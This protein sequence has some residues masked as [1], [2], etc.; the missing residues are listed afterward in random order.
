[1]HIVRRAKLLAKPEVRAAVEKIAEVIREALPGGSFAENELAAHAMTGEA[2]RAVLEEKLQR[3]ADSFGDRVLVGDVEFKRHEPGTVNVYSLCGT[4]RPRRFTFRQ[5][6]V[7]NGPTVDPMALVAG[8]V[9]GATPALAYSV[10]HGYAQ[11]DMRAHGEA[12]EAAERVAPPRATLERL[13]K[14]IAQQADEVL[15]R[16]EPMLRRAEAVPAAAR[17]VS[18]GL[19]R[20]SVL[21]S[22]ERPADAPPK[23][24]RK[25]KKPRIRRPSPPVDVNWRMAY[26]GTVSIVDADG[27]ALTSRRYAVPACDDPS[28][29][30]ARMCADVE[31]A[32][33]CAPYLEV[34][35]V[36]DGAPEMWNVTRGG[37]EQLLECGV[38]PGWHEG[39][40]R[41][42]LLERLAAAL[43]IIEPDAEE[44]R[45]VLDEWR[46]RLDAQDSAIDSIEHYLTR[47]YNEASPKQQEQLWEH[48]RYLQNNK[49]RMRYVT[50]QTAGLPVGS[51]VTESAAKTVVGRRAKN[52]GQRWKE[53]GLRGVLTLRALHQSQR[54]PPFW[55]RFSRRYAKHVEAA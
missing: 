30:V 53:P 5:V 25:R 15:P 44:R 4:L 6:G 51:G 20:T 40:D 7:H 9:E 31:A 36:Q 47:R 35:I 24:T 43:V 45:Q 32:V 50:L 37:L 3:I 12:L 14:R 49:D 19:D 34:G 23:E 16:V 26:V 42:H 48:L 2:V 29:V 10:A 13:A 22:E 41:F 28:E 52:A 8:L 54:L 55:S 46:N 39:I 21:M 18:I 17:A 38:I 33:R 1:M 11:H 27:E